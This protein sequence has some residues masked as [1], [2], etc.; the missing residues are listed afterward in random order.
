MVLLIVGG[1]GGVVECF[2][3]SV[4]MTTPSSSE[5]VFTQVPTSDP[6]SGKDGAELVEVKQMTRFGFES[7]TGTRCDTLGAVL[8]TRSYVSSCCC[9]YLGFQDPSKFD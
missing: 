5:M 3:E 2:Q 8:A 1:L 6:G 7:L 9:F 4:R